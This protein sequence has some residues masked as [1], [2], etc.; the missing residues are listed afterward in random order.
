MHI[1]Y[2]LDRRK[3]MVERH[4]GVKKHEERL[5]NMEHI[6]HRPSRSGLKIADAVISNVA[7]GTSSQWW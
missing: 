7:N 3:S 5:G 6:F 1:R 2:D 4:D